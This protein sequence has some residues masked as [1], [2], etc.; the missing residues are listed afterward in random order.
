MPSDITSQ[1]FMGPPSPVQILSARYQTT[2]ALASVQILIRIIRTIRNAT[3][4][5][6]ITMPEITHSV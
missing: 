6:I 1:N 2:M 3:L 5:L 4:P